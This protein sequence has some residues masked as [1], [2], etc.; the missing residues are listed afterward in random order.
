[1]YWIIAARIFVVTILDVL[2][3]KIKLWKSQEAV[4]QGKQTDE[5]KIITGNYFILSKKNFRHIL[6][7]NLHRLFVHY[8]LLLIISYVFLEWYKHGF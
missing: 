4:N 7:E 1:M 8:F 5:A 3:L 6:W 2:L